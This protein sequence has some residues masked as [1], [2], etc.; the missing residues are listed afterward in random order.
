MTTRR[1]STDEYVPGT[2]AH[3]IAQLRDSLDDFGVAVRDAAQEF[4][5]LV[6]AMR[7]DDKE[8]R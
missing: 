4:A 7:N 2:T 8:E 1:R 3:A 6:V 5:R